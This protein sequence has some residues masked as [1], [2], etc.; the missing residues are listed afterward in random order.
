MSILIMLMFV[1]RGCQRWCPLVLGVGWGPSTTPTALWKEP[2]QIHGHQCPIH[3]QQRSSLISSRKFE[4]DRDCQWMVAVFTYPQK[5]AHLKRLAPFLARDISIGHLARPSADAPT[6][7]ARAQSYS[8]QTQ[9]ALCDA[10]HHHHGSMHNMI[11]Q[12]FLQSL[13][14]HYNGGLLCATSPVSLRTVIALKVT[15]SWRGISF[16]QIC[17]NEAIDCSC[18]IDCVLSGR[19]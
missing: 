11:K 9:F 15:K 6:H 4:K 16:E 1:N 5:S 8:N 3:M 10:R 12:D 2:T 7:P 14:R 13:Q 19:W 17:S 18:I